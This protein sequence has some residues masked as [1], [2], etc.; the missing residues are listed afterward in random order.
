[1]GRGYLD[2]VIRPSRGSTTCSPRLRRRRGLARE[3]GRGGGAKYR[4]VGGI[5]APG[6]P[7]TDGVE[8]VV[9]PGERGNLGGLVADNQIHLLVMP[10]EV[11]RLNVFNEIAATCLHLPV[12]LWELS[13]FYEDVFGH[14]PV[15]EIN[16][17]WFQYIMHPNYRYSPP[18]SKRALDLAVSVTVGI[19]A[20]PAMLLF[21]LLIRRDGR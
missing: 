10:S 7:Q 16:A 20:L 14:V 21:A 4:V 9:K 18:A 15:A 11:P 6:L 8:G 17:S 1:M 2:P 13:G 12:R 19:V 5:G 3:M